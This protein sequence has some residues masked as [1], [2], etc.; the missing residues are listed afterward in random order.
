MLPL[1]ASWF[2]VEFCSPAEWVV[3]NLVVASG[4]LLSSLLL[5]LCSGAAFIV[6]WYPQVR[7]EGVCYAF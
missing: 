3:R 1:L 7:I 6:N 5:V 4:T 2:L